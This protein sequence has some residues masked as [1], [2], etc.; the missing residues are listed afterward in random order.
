VKVPAATSAT[1]AEIGFDGTKVMFFGHSQ[2]GLNGPLFLAGS[3]LARG[4]VLSGAG[5]D[6]ALN[7]LEKTKPVDVAA[8]FRVLVGLGDR[9]VAT[10]LDI[11]HPVMTLVQSIVDAADPL[12]YGGFIARAPRPGHT[13]KSIYQTEGV[14]PDGAGDSYAPPHGIEALSVAIGLPRQLPGVR[15]VVEA[16]WAG[17]AD[18][19]IPSDGLSGNIGDGRASGVLAQ[20]VPAAGRDGHFVVFSDPKARGQAA[21]FLANLGADAKGRVPAP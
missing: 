17:I 10:E 7:L 3:D 11:F 15:P 5:S 14:G 1:G 8:A 20:F 12:S 21:A 16:R 18:V 6:L 9:E 19:S 4:G 2:G 13:P